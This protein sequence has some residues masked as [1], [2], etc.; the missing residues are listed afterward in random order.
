[1]AT[2]GELM[3]ISMNQ[4][5][6]EPEDE[7]CREAQQHDPRNQALKLQASSTA[8][9]T[10]ASS[11]PLQIS[12]TFH[13]GDLISDLRCLRRGPPGGHV[14]HCGGMT[15][16]TTPTQI[17]SSRTTFR[18]RDST[19]VSLQE[20]VLRFHP[21]AALRQTNHSITIAPR[22]YVPVHR[23]SGPAMRRTCPATF[24]D[25]RVGH[26]SN[27]QNSSTPKVFRYLSTP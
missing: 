9:L 16:T 21:R 20:L 3:G 15:S 24:P 23:A 6:A 14:R 19:Q 17:S 12:F 27:M 4:S 10:S 2:V 1:M 25:P 7:T 5:G 26:G 11:S 18:S 13:C 8:S 22:S